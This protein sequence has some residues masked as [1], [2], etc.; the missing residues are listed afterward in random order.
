MN[1][2]KN[3][4]KKNYA[5]SFKGIRY[6]IF[7]DYLLNLFPLFCCYVILNYFSLN[8]QYMH[9][10]ILKGFPNQYILERCA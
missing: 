4:I 2:K 9:A 7:I 8:A 5:L 3:Y 10:I 6:I 1:L